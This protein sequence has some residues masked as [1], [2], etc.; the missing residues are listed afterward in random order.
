MA[1]DM[2]VI[3]INEFLRTNVTGTIDPGASRTILKD[4]L[5]VWHST[6]SNTS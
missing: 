2:R 3:P 6:E 4:L 1:Y 5:T